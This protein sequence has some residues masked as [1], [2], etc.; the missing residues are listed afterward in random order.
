MVRALSFVAALALA[1]AG[2]S[3]QQ[4]CTTDARQIVNE[5]YRNMLERSA[6]RASDRFVQRLNGGTTVREIVRELAVSPEHTQRFVP[7]GNAEAQRN[8]VTNLFRH[9]LG[10]QPDP[11]GLQAHMNGLATQGVAAVVDNMIG[12]DEYANSFGDFGV[13]GSSGLRYCGSGQTSSIQGD[14]SRFAAMDA[15]R[16]GI[17]TQRE[18][19]GS[20]QAFRNNDWNGDGVLAGEEVRPGGRRDSNVVGTAGRVTGLTD[21]AFDSLDRNG[22]GRLERNE[23]NGT[24]AEFERLDAN[25]NN[26]LSRAEAVATTSG[27]SGTAVSNNLWRE[28]NE[29]DIDADGRISLQEWNWNRRTFDQQDANRDGV[30]LPREFSGAPTS[31]PNTFGR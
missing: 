12:S 20:A 11:G 29:L 8:G 15:N 27:T 7:G 25:A 24:A 17:I 30:I 21:G 28:F 2:A 1:P 23:W 22:N 3:A 13:P 18:W 10:R 5:L 26:L 4:P 19:N 9:V 14:R 16:D 6:D 31:S